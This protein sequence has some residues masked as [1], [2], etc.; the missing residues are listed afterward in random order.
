MPQDTL[1]ME[2]ITDIIKILFTEFYLEKENHIKA[3][4]GNILNLHL[5]IQENLEKPIDKKQ[6][7]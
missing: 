1:Q 6:Y 5:Q 4:F 3:V 2:K 7:L